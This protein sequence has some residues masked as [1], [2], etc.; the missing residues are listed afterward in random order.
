MRLVTGHAPRE[1][2]PQLIGERRLH[3]RLGR[4]L[5]RSHLGLVVLAQ[6]ADGAQKPRVLLLQLSH[7]LEVDE[8]RR[9]HPVGRVRP[10]ESRAGG[11]GERRKGAACATRRDAKV[12]ASRRGG[13]AA[14]AGRREAEGRRACGEPAAAGNGGG[15]GRFVDPGGL[16]NSGSTNWLASSGGSHTVI[17]RG[18]SYRVLARC[19]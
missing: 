1:Q 8:I 13:R 5:L 6:P 3:R 18:R 2:R 15:G 12:A 4:V 16:C 7:V 9:D 14:W 10:R 11:G 19:P 17:A